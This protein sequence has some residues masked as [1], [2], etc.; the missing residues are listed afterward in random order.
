MGN[1]LAEDMIWLEVSEKLVLQAADNP[2]RKHREQGT[3]VYMDTQEEWDLW[4]DGGLGR[5]HAGAMGTKRARNKEW[6]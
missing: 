4:E 3:L 2:G 6:P 5:A 1:G